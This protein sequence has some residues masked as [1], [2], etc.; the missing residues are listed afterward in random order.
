MATF[1]RIRRGAA[2][3]GLA[4]A[5]LCPGAFR[6]WQV[7]QHPGLTYACTVGHICRAIRKLAA[8][9]TPEEAT[10]RLYRG[11]RGNLERAFWLPDSTGLVCAVDMAFMSTSRARH[12]PI[13]YMSDD[14]QNVMW[15]LKPQVESDTAYHYGAD[16]S[17]LS[18][19]GEEKEV[20]YP[21]CT[22]LQVQRVLRPER[23]G[24]GGG[25]MA[26]SLPSLHAGMDELITHVGAKASKVTEDDK[27]FLSIDVL[28]RYV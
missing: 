12:A 15:A 5:P 8:V 27:C 23:G 24:A 11:V 17:S 26:P 18:Q 25:G 14:A 10:A 13:A 1:A 6:K 3:E 16:I 20:L 4:H 28:P 19:F 22:M 9:A 7:A 21:P 2:G